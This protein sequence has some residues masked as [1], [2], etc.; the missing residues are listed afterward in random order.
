M[1]RICMLPTEL[2]FTEHISMCGNLVINVRI[3]STLDRSVPKSLVVEESIVCT[4]FCVTDSIART[5]L[6][7]N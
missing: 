3:F 7:K 2:S 4:Q 6:K 5:L 1:Q